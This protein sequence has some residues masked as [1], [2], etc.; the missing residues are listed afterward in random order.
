M[1]TFVVLIVGAIDLTRWMYAIDAAGEAV[2]EGARVAVVC[3]LNAGAIQTRMSR[4]LV[5]ATGGS[6]TVTYTPSGCCASLASCSPAC[7]GVSVTV[8]GY[9]VP[10]IAPFLPTMNLPTITNYLPRESLDSTNN[11]RCS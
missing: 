6:A 2:R 4:S 11:A 7:T 9:Q 1:S 5:T 10:R 8:T 3:N